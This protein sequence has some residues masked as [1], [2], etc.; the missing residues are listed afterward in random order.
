MVVE[1]VFTERSVERVVAGAFVSL[2]LNTGLFPC[3]V[4]PKILEISIHRAALFGTQHLK[5][6]GSFFYM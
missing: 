2:S 6:R 1:S 3:R 4:M 5:N